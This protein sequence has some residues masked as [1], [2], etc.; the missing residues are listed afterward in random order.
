MSW[1][2]RPVQ[3]PFHL[4]ALLG[5][6][7]LS[8]WLRGTRSRAPGETRGRGRAEL[9]RG[10]GSAAR[11]EAGTGAG[12]RG[13]EERG[14]VDRG[15]ERRLR[16]GARHDARPGNT[17]HSSRALSCA[18][19]R[20]PRGWST[21][22]PSPRVLHV[23]QASSDLAARLKLQPASSKPGS[24]DPS[25]SQRD[26]RAGSEKRRWPRLEQ[27]ARGGRAGG[28]QIPRRGATLRHL[29]TRYRESLAAFFSP[30]PL[31]SPKP[32]ARCVP[33]KLEPWGRDLSR[34]SHLFPE[35]S[36]RGERPSLPSI[37]RPVPA[38][39]WTRGNFDSRELQFPMCW[40]W[41]DAR[42]P[43]PRFRTATFAGFALRAAES[44]WV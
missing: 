38:R 33:P 8:G 34:Q 23:G 13:A 6:G 31:P 27:V 11:Q 35:R 42:Q 12:P 4:G 32:S 26:L 20:G 22:V 15:L 40:P 5:S 10:E 28:E 2:P 24:G 36:S 18:E 37:P 3:A 39:G 9:G 19:K 43:E 41:R 29:R 30:T 21:L 25:G 1:H 16:L 17:S 44:I 7:S 14:K